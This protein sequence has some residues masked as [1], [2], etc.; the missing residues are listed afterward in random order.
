MGIT[1]IFELTGVWY[2]L[3]AVPSHRVLRFSKCHN[4]MMRAAS[5]TLGRHERGISEAKKTT[6]VRQETLPKRRFVAPKTQ[7]PEVLFLRRKP[8]FLGRIPLMVLE[9]CTLYNS[10]HT[11]P[12]YIHTMHFY[13]E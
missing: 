3:E 7:C 11:V 6:A 9:L 13:Q 1:I 12:F 2:D 5:S 8:N 10:I 4:Q